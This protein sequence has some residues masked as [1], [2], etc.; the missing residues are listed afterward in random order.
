MGMQSDGNL[1]L[2]HSGQEVWSSGTKSPYPNTYFADFS[3]SGYFCVTEPHEIGTYDDSWVW[4]TATRVKSPDEESIE[5]TD[6]NLLHGMDMFINED[7]NWQFNYLGTKVDGSDLPPF[8][9][10]KPCDYEINKSAAV[11]GF[12]GAATFIAYILS[13]MG[14]LTTVVIGYVVV[15]RKRAENVYEK[16]QEEPSVPADYSCAVS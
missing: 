16:Y 4:K 2:L 13:L 15:R 3:D 10:G 11:T 7:G 12:V 6:S 9:I 14:V 1:V 5:D 8:D